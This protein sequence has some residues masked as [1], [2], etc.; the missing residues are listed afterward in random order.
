[1]G[2]NN[3]MSGVNK[4]QSNGKGTNSYALDMNGTGSP[5]IVV[6]D[7]AKIKAFGEK[8]YKAADMN[9]SSITNIDK[10]LQKKRGEV[11]RDM[12]LA[13]HESRVVPQR[14]NPQQKAPAKG[15]KPARSKTQP[16]S[17]ESDYDKFITLT[18]NRYDKLGE[19]L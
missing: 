18:A 10:V 12:S 9:P 17:F 13:H 2:E 7:T 3:T 11:K 14:S 1:M 16:Q 8:L 5:N 15:Q 4:K 19:L 6:Q